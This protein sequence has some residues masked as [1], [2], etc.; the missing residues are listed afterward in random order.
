MVL[1]AV[2]FYYVEFGFGSG[3]KINSRHMQTSFGQQLGDLSYTST[4]FINVLFAM[5]LL[6]LADEVSRRVKVNDN[7]ARFYRWQKH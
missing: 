4:D 2:G 3:L 5:V 6:Y 7:I 1:G